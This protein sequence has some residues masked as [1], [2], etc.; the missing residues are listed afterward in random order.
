MFD[1]VPGQEHAK[2][3]RPRAARAAQPRLSAR[4]RPGLAKNVFA[5]ELGVALVDAPCGGCGALRP[6]ATRARARPAPRPARGRARGR[7]DP[8]RPDRSVGRRSRP[9]AVLRPSR[10]V[11]VIPEAEQLTAAAANKLLKSIEEPPAFVYF[12]LVTDRL[13]RVLPTIV[14]RCQMVEFRPLSD[15]QVD[16][17]VRER[18]GLAGDEA[19]ALA[20]L[21]RG[22]V[23]RAARLAEDARGPRAARAQYLRGGARAAAGERGRDGPD[24]AR[25]SSTS[26]SATRASQGGLAERARGARRR[27]GAPVPGQAR[28]RWHG[29]HAEARPSARRR[30]C[31]ASPLRTPSTCS[32]RGCATSGWSPAG[33]PMYSGTATAP[34]SSPAAAV[35]T[36]ELLR[37]PAGGHRPDAQGPV[38]E[39]RPQARAAGHVRALRGGR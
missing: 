19:V 35:A 38:S 25:R 21:S 18:F 11:W 6:S 9:Q 31:A 16:A 8:P 4:R 36:P 39:R 26:S 22:S 20:R 28:P 10:R 33:L 1:L 17:Y 23:E 5:R 2:D 32:P 7:A 34:A 30:A 29:K 24:P 27:A 15:E 13:E 3:F 14:S 37:A 12:L